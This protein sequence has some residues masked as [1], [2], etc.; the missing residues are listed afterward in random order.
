[1]EGYG[2]IV[3]EVCFPYALRNKTKELTFLYGKLDESSYLSNIQSPTRTKLNNI[4]NTCA[5]DSVLTAMFAHYPEFCHNV[6]HKNKARSQIVEWVKTISSQVSIENLV[7]LF[8]AFPSEDNFHILGDPKDAIEFLLYFLKIFAKDVTSTK[9][10][11]TINKGIVTCTTI[12]RE[13]SPVQYIPANS[14]ATMDNVSIR[15]FLV[16]SNIVGADGKTTTEEIIQ[17]DI[18]VFAFGRINYDGSFLYTKVHPTP[19]LTTPN[20]DRFF[21]G[22]IV[23]VSNS[24][25]ISYIRDRN[26]WYVYDDMGSEKYRVVGSFS[27]LYSCTPSP[28]TNG[29]LYFYF[30]D[31]SCVEEHL[32][33]R[34]ETHDNLHVG[35]FSDVITDKLI[36][37]HSMF[38]TVKVSDSLGELK[39]LLEKNEG[40]PYLDIYDVKTYLRKLKHV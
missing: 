40:P 13:S 12:D 9:I 30:P 16:N 8:G 35:V 31:Y 28:V 2:D 5:I 23:V 1:M 27:D 20:G 24:H 19:S 6:E 3:T 21:L 11:K 22:S 38:N 34:W 29:V 37:I 15:D 7:G 39:N 18:V 14:L 4:G 17:S 10:F 26:M 32:L 33:S 36:N 25:Y